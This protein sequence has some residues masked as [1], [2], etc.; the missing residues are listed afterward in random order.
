MTALITGASAGIGR[1]L[2]DGLAERGFRLVLTARDAAR[3]EQAAGELRRRFGVE[4]SVVPQDLSDPAGPEQL[5]ETLAARG[6]TVDILVN[7][8]GLGA[9]E[10]FAE[11]QIARQAAMLQVN[12]VALTKLTRLLLPGMIARSGGRILNVSSMAAYLP[13]PLMAVYYATK[14]YVSSFSEALSAELEGSGVTVTAL[15]PGG[16]A[17]EFQERAGMKRGGRYRRRSMTAE[18]VARVGIAALLAG[19]RVAIPGWGNWFLYFLIRFSPRA[20][21]IRS[22]RLLNQS[23]LGR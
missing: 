1:A 8:A 2:A 11:G 17:T 15:C 10:R 16:T 20:L 7:N 9:V 21:V 4:V 6:L 3:L 12:V 23:L 13:G 19:R 18:A 22:V 5:V 14:A